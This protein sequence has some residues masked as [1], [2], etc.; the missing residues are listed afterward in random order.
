M[1]LL[2]VLW[3]KR[4]ESNPLCF[5]LCESAETAAE[6]PVWACFRSLLQLIVSQGQILL[7][8]SFSNLCSRIS[9]MC[10]F[11]FY[12]SAAADWIMLQGY[13]WDTR[14]F[15]IFFLFAL[16]QSHWLMK[17]KLFQCQSMQWKRKLYNC[18]YKSSGL[19]TFVQVWFGY[20]QLPEASTR[21]SIK[22]APTPQA[23]LQTFCFY[24]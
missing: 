8:P 23:A 4:T 12:S 5:Y 6:L 24:V 20:R 9:G 18:T 22:L 14:Y 13:K 10:Y 1:W 15:S 17:E 19:F 21:L 16:A 3:R 7:P 11:H 2:S